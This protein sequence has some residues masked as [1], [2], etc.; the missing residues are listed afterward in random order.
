MILTA[1]ANPAWDV[2]YEVGSLMPGTLHRVTRVHRRLGGK[3][4]NVARVLTSLG[5]AAT[6]I[7][8]GTEGLAD[9]GLAIDVVPGVP[10]IRQTLVVQGADGMTTSLWEPGLPIDSAAE[11]AF[12]ARV[13]AGLAA[14]AAGLVVAGSLPPGADPGLPARLAA[15]ASGA[16]VPV[17]VD[18]SG[19]PLSR[20]TRVPGVILTPNSE[21]LAHLAGDA[22]PVSA[23]RELLA[24]GPRAVIVTLGADGMVAVTA[25]G[26]WHGRLPEAVRGNPTGA[27]D[28][29][30]AALIAG[31]TGGDTWPEIV[32]DAVALSAAAV[33]SPVAG[34]AD[35]KLYAEFLTRVEVTPL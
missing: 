16:G 6:A 28:A 24:S 10:A 17:I 3:G 5:H 8:L 2:T 1:T 32:R 12:A 25:E 15:A 30:A 27:G 33:A 21:E 35:P 26:R 4:V 14:G 31:L 22:D 23:A 34:E 7:V 29:A 19:E 20:A 18:T 13:S 11:A 9:V